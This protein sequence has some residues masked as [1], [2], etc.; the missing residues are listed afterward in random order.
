MAL[1][2]APVPPLCQTMEFHHSGFQLAKTLGVDHQARKTTVVVLISLKQAVW[3]T[4]HPSAK[5][6]THVQIIERI[7]AYDKQPNQC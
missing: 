4:L 2:R 3:L 7:I 6:S 1:G 5:G